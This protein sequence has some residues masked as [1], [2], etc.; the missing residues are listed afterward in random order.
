MVA[1]FNFYLVQSSPKWW[2]LHACK[3]FPD[4]DGAYCLAGELHQT[5]WFTPIPHRYLLLPGICVQSLPGYQGL[6]ATECK[7]EWV[8]TWVLCCGSPVEGK[9]NSCRGRLWKGAWSAGWCLEDPDLVHDKIWLGY[10]CFVSEIAFSLLSR[11]LCSVCGAPLCALH[12]KIVTLLWSYRRSPWI[13][14][15]SP[16]CSFTIKCIL[17]NGNILDHSTL[18]LC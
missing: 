4:M 13:K 9:H 15:A 5:P 7:E 1:A 3:G 18:S 6:E 2:L 16:L 17:H 12:S 14:S 11:S 10:C 8:W